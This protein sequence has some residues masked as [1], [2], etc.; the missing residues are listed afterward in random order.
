MLRTHRAGKGPGGCVGWGLGSRKRGGSG[1]P[2]TPVLRGRGTS[3]WSPAGFLGSSGQGK[4][5]PL[6]SC[7]SCLGVF[8]LPASPD[9]CGLP[10]MS[11]G[12]MWGGEWGPWRAGDRPGCS[13]GSRA[14]VGRAIALI[15]LLLLPQDPSPCLS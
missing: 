6:L 15:P 9:L 12:P 5:P 8:L 7:S 10:P 13:P 3:P 11:P 14:R 4:C 1:M 2:P